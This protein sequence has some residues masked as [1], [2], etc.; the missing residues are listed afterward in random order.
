MNGDIFYRMKIP[1]YLATLRY[2]VAT[3]MLR[4]ANKLLV[5]VG[6]ML[7]VVAIS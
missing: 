5:S 2:T 6:E 4:V 3:Y 1:E 7:R